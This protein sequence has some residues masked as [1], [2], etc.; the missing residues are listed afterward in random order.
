MVLMSSLEDDTD[1]ASRL[2]EQEEPTSDGEVARGDGTG[3]LQEN[4]QGAAEI[5]TFGT[6]WDE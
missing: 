6:T 1:T 2:E 4:D 3:A 5:D